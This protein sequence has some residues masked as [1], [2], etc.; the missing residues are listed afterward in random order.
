M[1]L[2]DSQP[3][4]SEMSAH[5]KE[6]FWSGQEEED[7]LDSFGLTHDEAVNKKRGFKP[8]NQF[9]DNIDGGD[10]HKKKKQKKW[11]NSGGNNSGVKQQYQSTEKKIW[12]SE[13]PNMHWKSLDEEELK[14]LYPES[15]VPLK[16]PIHDLY[17]TDEDGK[18]TL[19]PLM[20]SHRFK[21][22]SEA[23]MAW[24][25]GK[26]GASSLSY[27][28]GLHSGFAKG[29]MSEIIYDTDEE[30]ANDFL[31][32]IYNI[33]T[34]FGPF[35]T[36]AMEWGTLHE[37]TNIH[38]ILSVYGKAMDFYES[39]S[40]VVNAMD[41]KGKKFDYIMF[42]SPDG[43]MEPKSDYIL[44]DERIQNGCSVEMKCVFP[45]RQTNRSKNG[46][47]VVPI[48]AYMKHKKPYK[49]VVPPKYVPQTQAQMYALNKEVS[50]FSCYSPTNGTKISWLPYDEDYCYLM[51][52]VVDWAFKTY[53]PNMDGFI[54][55]SDYK[56]NKSILEPKVSY[57]TLEELKKAKGYSIV[58]KNKNN[59]F[60]DCPYYNK[61]L[62]RTLELS[63]TTL[64]GTSS[65]LYEDNT[66]PYS[67]TGL[68]NKYKKNSLFA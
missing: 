29:F 38:K 47:Q 22:R 17:D 62:K 58:P 21:Q 40:Y 11:S 65:M 64:K 60:E 26:V 43:K 19:V 10:V 48:Y 67:D 6:T 32:K 23:W 30:Y 45:F 68:V 53:N 16:N 41:E 34:S 37:E 1:W 12:E 8:G 57:K 44:E 59:P 50:L 2:I 20:L 39:G 5:S 51:F 33:K 25:Q 28:T 13:N 56:E 54:K 49:E 4:I 55:R 61:Y 7:L 63:K 66:V 18:K 52:K 3:Q 27:L 31:C 36:K 15:Y 9:F 24:R 35:V 14:Y 46:E 42:V